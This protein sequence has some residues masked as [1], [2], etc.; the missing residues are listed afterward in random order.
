MLYILVIILIFIGIIVNKKYKIPLHLPVV[1]IILYCILSDN[2][3]YVPEVVKT[4]SG[5][6]LTIHTELPDF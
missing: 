1:G 4:I 6:G 5:G 3:E 2:K